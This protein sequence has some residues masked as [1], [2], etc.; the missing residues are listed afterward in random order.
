[1]SLTKTCFAGVL[2]LGSTLWGI[3]A[4]ADT[5]VWQD[6]SQQNGSAAATRPTSTVDWEQRS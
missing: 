6:V 3:R 5:E 2:L 4:S 1:M